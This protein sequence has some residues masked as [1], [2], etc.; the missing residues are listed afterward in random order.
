MPKATVT[1]DHIRHDL[2]SCPGG[3]VVLRQLP[4][5]DV[6]VRR[7]GAARLSVEQQ[8][9]DD[10]R[11]LIETMQ[12]W[13]R[14]FEFRQCIVDHNLDDDNGVRLDFNNP[15]AFRTLDPRIGKEIESLID[16]LNGESEDDNKEDFTNVASLLSEVER[17]RDKQENV[18]VE[19]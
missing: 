5:G 16:E 6:L 18:T 19:T 12:T 14:E 1:Q 15:F 10:S 11:M 8:Q 2:K 13:A 3:F 17:E 7:D 9:A 4:Y